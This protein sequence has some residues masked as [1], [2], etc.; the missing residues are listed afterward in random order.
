MAKRTLQLHVNT[1]PV[2]LDLAP[3]TLLIDL[4]REPLQLRG[5]HQVCDTAQ[6]GACTVLV[7]GAAVKSC[8][9][10]ALQCAGR[11]VTTIEG[12]APADGPLHVMQALF[13]KH[14]AL[15]CGY[16]TPGFVLRAVAMVQEDVPAEPDAVRQALSGNLCRCTGYEGIVQAVV[17]GLALLRNPAHA[18]AGAP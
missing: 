5:T 18:G 2:T 6:C 14:H 11:S 13:R 4:L 9:R 1:V 3:S 7:D 16:C 15:Q 8:N 12:L 10:L 17:E